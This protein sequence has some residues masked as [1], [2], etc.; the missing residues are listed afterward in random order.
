LSKDQTHFLGAKPYRLL[1]KAR[2]LRRANVCLILRQA[3]DDAAIFR[4]LG[5]ILYEALRAGR[6]KDIPAATATSA[7]GNIAD[8]LGTG[9]THAFPA[10]VPRGTYVSGTGFGVTP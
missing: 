9:R 1:H 6:K 10:T 2:P 4:E 8:Y 3:Q 5:E 7:D